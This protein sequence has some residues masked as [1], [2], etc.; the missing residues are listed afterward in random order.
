VRSTGSVR[1]AELAAGAGN[2]LFLFLPC[3][4]DDLARLPAPAAA[5]MWCRCPTS[6][7]MCGRAEAMSCTRSL[8][9]TRR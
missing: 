1:P 9:T 2:L 8:T 5:P 7:P 3:P 6:P 4:R